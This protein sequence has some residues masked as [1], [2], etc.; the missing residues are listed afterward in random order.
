[1]LILTRKVDEAIVVGEHVVIKVVRIQGNQVHLGITA[2]RQ[3]AVHRLEVFEQ[4]RAANL[5]AAQAQAGGNLGE[6]AAKL[7]VAELNEEA[8]GNGATSP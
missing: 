7:T 1:M 8:Q 2:P 4:V 3:V 5:R 6:I